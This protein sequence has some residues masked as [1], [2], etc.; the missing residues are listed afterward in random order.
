VPIRRDTIFD[1]VTDTW[2][3]V[4][5]GTDI[6]K[7]INRLTF[8]KP[9]ISPTSLS[10]QIWQGQIE[11]IRPSTTETGL[12]DPALLGYSID[13]ATN[14]DWVA[15]AQ[16]FLIYLNGTLRATLRLTE[17]LAYNS[18]SGSGVGTLGHLANRI[19]KT[20]PQIT[21]I[22]RFNRGGVEN[23]TGSNTAGSTI[24]FK[25]ITPYN[26]AAKQ[27]I[28]DAVDGANN[29]VFT[30]ADVDFAIA[31]SNLESTTQFTGGAQTNGF[32]VPQ[33]A[34]DDTP[35]IKANAMLFQGGAVLIES[36]ADEKL[37]LSKQLPRAA[38]APIYRLPKEQFLYEP[39]QGSET[40]SVAARAE[41]VKASG[42][43]LSKAEIDESEYPKVDI[44]A[45]DPVTSAAVS[46]RST[47]K[48]SITGST[49]SQVITT[50]ATQDHVVGNGNST[51][52]T[53]Q[54]LTITQ[55]HD[56]RG[57]PSLITES[58]EEL[59]VD[60]SRDRYL[61]EVNQL[62]LVTGRTITKDWDYRAN[63]TTSRYTE[64]TTNRADVVLAAA[65]LGT[66]TQITQSREL[67]SYTQEQI[68]TQNRWLV[69]TTISQP[70]GIDAETTETALVGVSSN[71][72]YVD[73]L[74]EPT[75]KLE[76]DPVKFSF[77]TTEA[78]YRIGGTT[79]NSTPLETQD[80]AATA[81]NAAIV[82]RQKAYILAQQRLSW[83]VS[84]GIA[85]E[86]LNSFETIH[87]DDGN[88][89]VSLY[90]NGLVVE[91][92]GQTVR[93]SYRA[94]RLGTLTER[95]TADKTPVIPANP[96]GV[97]L[98]GSIPDITITA[99]ETM[100]PIPLTAFGGTGSYTFSAVGLPSGLSV[101]GAT[102]IK[103]GDVVASG[104]SV[105][106]TADDGATTDDASFTL[107]VAAAPVV[108]PHYSL[109]VA[110][111]FADVGTSFEATESVP[112]TL[113][114][115]VGGEVSGGVI[116]ILEPPVEIV[117]GEVSGGVIDVGTA[118][119][120]VTNIVGGEVSGGAVTAS[121][122]LLNNLVAWYE[123]DDTS[124]NRTDSHTGGYT[125]TEA[126]TVATATAKVGTN[127]VSGFSGSN[128]LTNGNSAFNFGDTD[129]YF[130]AW[131]YPSTVAGNAT[132]LGRWDFGES[133]RSYTFLRVGSDIYWRVSADGSASV[134]AILS[135][136]LSVNTWHFIEGYHDAAG[137][138]IGIAIDGG[139]FVT[140]AHSS[141]VYSGGTV[142]F[143]IGVEFEN[144]VAGNPW[145]GRI[146]NVTVHS[147]LLNS[148]ERAELYNSGL[149]K[150]YPI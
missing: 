77:F 45:I 83:T 9:Q 68:G 11:V 94:D 113:T 82:A 150:A 141:G 119:P 6:T 58:Y 62:N 50:T 116:E 10:P 96:T 86:A 30:D 146:D 78:Q 106:I 49:K 140:T 47:A 38:D 118:A 34:G 24:T 54:R 37:Y 21:T 145:T 109:V 8:G 40:D 15:F 46:W 79:S 135:G 122:T 36:R 137:N 48:P 61:G 80:L 63:G 7:I 1:L 143:G 13:P 76:T 23:S 127:A 22:V 59:L 52:I 85:D 67:T 112:Q 97:L 41:V 102:I 103:T 99:N 117:G 98:A 60:L 31:A 51:V 121:E 16:P 18:Q 25:I 75:P 126:G 144:N 65:T 142:D 92:Q 129:F 134:N 64:T 101:S 95:V 149:G 4:V 73:N 56:S 123:L 5:G 57:W 72:Q 35:L 93:L 125:L 88:Q 84:H 55:N 111:S 53:R 17:D 89:A 87:L 147:R 26:I 120:A 91:I 105:T 33:P 32:D 43:S 131:I 107:T 100:T 148:S 42:V 74:A 70:K 128:H 29:S 114:K 133:A 124:G 44:I 110:D 71:V 12:S 108:T 104:Y 138:E 139:S 132:V 130:T 14:T 90:R 3:V 2:Q 19:E 136:A 81:E 115:I 20:V 66:S 28:V 69:T 27:L 39:I